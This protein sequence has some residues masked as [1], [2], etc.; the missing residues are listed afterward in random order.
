VVALLHLFDTHLCYNAVLYTH[1]QQAGISWCC[2]NSLAAA[3]KIIVS[4]VFLP[5]IHQ[6]VS[7]FLPLAANLSHTFSVAKKRISP[8]SEARTYMLKSGAV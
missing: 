3:V 6:N 5:D 2:N 7:V 4:E 8:Q 1:S